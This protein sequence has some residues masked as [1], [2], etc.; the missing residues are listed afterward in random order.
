MIGGSI[1]LL[2]AQGCRCTVNKHGQEF[3]LS[4]HRFILCMCRALVANPHPTFIWLRMTKAR[5]SWST[6]IPRSIYCL[7]DI[8]CCLH[9]QW[10]WCVHDTVKPEAC[11]H[12]INSNSPFGWVRSWSVELAADNTYGLSLPRWSDVIDDREAYLYRY[13]Q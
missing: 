13:G 5:C 12:R 2:Y 11:A 3:V 1:A 7:S 6:R 10:G 8:K 4:Y 9:A